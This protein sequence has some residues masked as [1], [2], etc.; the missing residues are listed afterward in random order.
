MFK[1]CKYP[2]T[3]EKSQMKKKIFI[4][5]LLLIITGTTI[6]NAY[7]Q[8]LTQNQY[9]IAKMKEELA[10]YKGDQSIYMSLCFLYSK[11]NDY[12]NMLNMMKTILKKFP[13]DTATAGVIND[14]AIEYSQKGKYDIA[15]KIV[16][17]T[18]SK[19]KRDQDA[20]IIRSE[21]L[22][23]QNRIDENNR[24]LESFLKKNP[25][26]YLLYDRL[27]DSY[28]YKEDYTNAFKTIRTIQDI[29]IENIY[30]YFVEAMILQ[31]TDKE[32]ALKY[33]K[34][35]FEKTQ[36]VEEYEP[37]IKIAKRIYDLLQSNDVT[38]TDYEEL[39]D[40]MK[41][42]KVPNSY[43][44]IQARY[45]KKLFPESPYFETVIENIYSKIGISH[46]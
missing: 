36:F 41:T 24:F 17:I 26:E 8:P 40:Y 3:C 16:D 42:S 7:S 19:Y 35:Y 43:I 2:L 34:A 31:M 33:F 38:A 23:K 9:A 1:G 44:L 25:K 28:I 32:K 20:A 18:L 46:S 21:I 30:Y 5:L 37:R 45:A 11:E 10:K 12:D 14:Y 13:K 27:A 29:N 6:D 22:L 4:A 15:L 39:L